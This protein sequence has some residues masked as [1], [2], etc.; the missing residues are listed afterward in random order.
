[1]TCVWRAVQSFVHRRHGHASA[2]RTARAPGRRP[3]DGTSDARA[4]AIEPR[5]N[6]LQPTVLVDTI[7]ELAAER[8]SDPSYRNDAA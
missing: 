6:Q 3:M 2:S 7:P 5:V 1:M 4:H 8:R